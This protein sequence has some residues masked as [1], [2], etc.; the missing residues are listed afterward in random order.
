MESKGTIA[1][2]SRSLVIHDHYEIDYRHSYAE[3]SPILHRA[4]K[5][6]APRLA[7]YGLPVY[8]CHPR[9]HCIECGEPTAWL[10]LPLS[11]RVHTFTTCHYGGELFL[12]E[13][14]F[15]L[16]LV[17]FDGADTLFL[18]R[19][20]GDQAGRGSHRPAGGRPFRQDPI[21]Q[22]DGCLVR[23]CRQDVKRET[24]LALADRVKAGEVRAVSRVDHLVGE[25]EPGRHRRSSTACLGLAPC[26][27][28][29]NY[30]LSGS[31]QEHGGRSTRGSLSESRHEGRSSS[32]RYQQPSD[33][34][35][36]ARRPHQDARAYA[37]SMES[38]S[39]AWPLVD[40]MEGSPERPA[41]QAWC[42]RRPGTRSF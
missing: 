5:G 42:W 35:R 17:E 4:D 37:R 41:T 14:P 30:R 22:G 11:G 13:T 23:A 28:D 38:I 18:S 25:S 39:E 26:G 7:L 33:G 21:V 15:T 8:L 2:R 3:D 34:R 27:C 36:L 16:I 12:K 6:T 31:W 24:T 32:R 10:E 19:L 20:K 1:L 29:R 9:A 40:T